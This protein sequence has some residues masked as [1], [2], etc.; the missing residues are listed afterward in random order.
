[1]QFKRPAGLSIR[2]VEGEVVILD[3]E[4]ER[5]HQ[6]NS[7]A[8]FVWN[9]LDREFDPAAVARELSEQFEVAE[10]VALSDVR[11]IIEELCELGLLIECGTA[12]REREG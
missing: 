3:R 12:G 2:V 10:S 4:R 9:K 7:T 6:L 8:S 5:I 1:M 11:R